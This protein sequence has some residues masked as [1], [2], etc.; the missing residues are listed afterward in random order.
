MRH[1]I[2]AGSG[3]MG[4]SMAQIFAGCDYKVTLYD[5]KAEALT[6]ARERIARSVE[7]LKESGEMDDSHAQCILNNIEY[8]SDIICFRQGEAV[9][10][11]IVENLEIKRRFYAEISQLTPD[12]TVIASNTSGLS[13]NAMAEAVRLPERFIGMHWFNPPHLILLVEIIRGDRTSDQTAQAIYDLC[14]AIGKKPVMVNKDVLGFAANR[15]QVALFREALA[16]VDQGVV[17]P[18]G[19]DDVMKYGLGFRY[20]CVGPMEIADLGGL[21]VWNH[22]SAYV[23]PDLCAETV[24]PQSITGRVERGELGV[25]TGKGFYDY[26]EGQGEQLVKER[27]R[28]MIAIYNALYKG[29]GKG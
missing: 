13:I 6:A 22:V 26:S 19:I 18:E 8:T 5:I 14:L 2:I 16:L 9:I 23:A 1:L 3:T 12:D 21:D 10:E 25:K 4:A 29:N 17:S 7:T 28:R 15:L 20:A 27:D 11:N 24:M